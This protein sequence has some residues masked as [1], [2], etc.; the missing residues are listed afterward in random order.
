MGFFINTKQKDIFIDIDGSIH[1]ESQTNRIVTFM[2]KQKGYLSDKQLFDDSQRKY[3]TDGL[4]AY[5]IQCY[6]DILDSN[7]K[8]MNIYDEND[9]MNLEEFINIIK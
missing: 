5:I 6:A 2:N 9:I 7:S 3:Q 1:D 8:I 4:D